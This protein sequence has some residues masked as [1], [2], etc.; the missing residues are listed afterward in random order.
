MSTRKTQNLCQE[1][2]PPRWDVDS[3]AVVRLSKSLSQKWAALRLMNN[4][5]GSKYMY[6]HGMKDG[7]KV[8]LLHMPRP[9]CIMQG[10]EITPLHG[11][12]LLTRNSTCRISPGCKAT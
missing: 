1:P 6:G 9:R 7:N 4:L 3:L 12:K 8:H 11:H 10:K 2:H 5:E